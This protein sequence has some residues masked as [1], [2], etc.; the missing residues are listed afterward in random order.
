MC[1]LTTHCPQISIFAFGAVFSGTW[2][3]LFIRLQHWKGNEGVD[4]WDDRIRLRL[5]QFCGF[6][7]AACLAGAVGFSARMRTRILRYA[8]QAPD[9]SDRSNYELGAL[10]SRVFVVYDMTHPLEYMCM[11]VALGILLRRVVRHASHRYYVQA[12]DAVDGPETSSEYSGSGQATAGCCRRWEPRDC[13]G[14]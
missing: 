8:A 10:E 2:L 6:M 12:R 7:C 5:G 1:T 3:G 14:E 13:I 11:F 9:I 4:V